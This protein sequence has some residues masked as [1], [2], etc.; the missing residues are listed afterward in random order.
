MIYYK[1]WLVCKDCFQVESHN[2]NFASS[3]TCVQLGR[4][5]ASAWHIPNLT[6]GGQQVISNDASTDNPS[7]WNHF[8][9]FWKWCYLPKIQVPC[10]QPRASILSWYF[11]GVIVSFFVCFVFVNLTKTRVIPHERTSVEEMPPSDW[12]I[13]M[14]LWHLLD[15]WLLWD[16]PTVGS[17]TSG[18]VVLGNIRKVA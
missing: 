6:P 13:G 15:C 9:T 12:P 3:S 18:H 14:S 11:K 7:T 8:Q 5:T 10:C 2:L 1:V 4:Q 17:V 16:K